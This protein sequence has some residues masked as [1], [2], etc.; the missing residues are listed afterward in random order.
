MEHIKR[1]DSIYFFYLVFFLFMINRLFFF[2]PGV[3]EQS[4]SCLLYPFFKIQSVLFYPFTSC[5]SQIRA[6]ST[7]QNKIDELVEQNQTLQA[8]LIEQVGMANFSEQTEEIVAFSRRYIVEQKKLAKVLLSIFSDKEDVFIIDG[9]TNQGI[10][11]DDVTVYKNLLIGRV[12]EVYP[13]YSKVALITDRRCKIS[14]Q[15][16]EGVVGIFSGQNNNRAELHF[17]PHFKKVELGEMILSTG[18]GLVYPQGFGL[19]EVVS[20]KTDNVSHSI[21]VKTL[22]DL[23][24]VSYVYVF[25]KI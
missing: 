20:I 24:T 2:S 16:K 23:S 13:W 14:A 10:Q 7:L 4:I 3:A 5:L 1:I 8:K 15:C 21:G 17:I 22:V 25:N 11:K 19:G 18:N 6:V 12:I 9:G